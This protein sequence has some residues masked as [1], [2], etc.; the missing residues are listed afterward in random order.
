[1][2]KEIDV[3]KNFDDMDKSFVTSKKPY[4]LAAI[5]G[6]FATGG[7]LMMLLRPVIGTTL[8]SYICLI[9]VIPLGVLG[10]Y[11]RHGID[12]ISYMKKRKN[13]RLYGRV[14]YDSSMDKDTGPMISTIAQ[15]MRGEEITYER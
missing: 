14:H 5:A 10:V 13:N 15:W 4:Q 12:F 11:E 7:A 6:A 1:M 9:A 8:T 3:N 2:Q